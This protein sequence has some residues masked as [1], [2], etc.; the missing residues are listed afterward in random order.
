MLETN[1]T[2][3]FMELESR[4]N[5]GC[6]SE[7]E[8]DVFRN[9]NTNY[10]DSSPINILQ[11]QAIFAELIQNHDKELDKLTGNK[12]LPSYYVELD[13]FISHWWL[14]HSRQYRCLWLRNLANRNGITFQDVEADCKRHPRF[15]TETLM[16]KEFKKTR[17][18]ELDQ[19]IKENDEN[20]DLAKSAH[21]M[22]EEGYKGVYSIVGFH[23]LEKK[24]RV[25]G[26]PKVK[27]QIIDDFLLMH[28]EIKSPISDEQALN[29]HV[30]SLRVLRE[31]FQEGAIKEIWYMYGALASSINH[32]NN[33]KVIEPDDDLEVNIFLSALDRAADLMTREQ[34][35]TLLM[36]LYDEYSNDQEW[37]KK[38]KKY[39]KTRVDQNVSENVRFAEDRTNPITIDPIELPLLISKGLYN[40]QEYKKNPYRCYDAYIQYHYFSGSTTIDDDIHFTEKEFQLLTE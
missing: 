38:W 37:S 18:E 31:M 20:S 8:L 11:D 32:F 3:S 13:N 40:I 5:K 19:I 26:P 35:Y 15:K 2:L 6:I 12:D 33:K 14:Y 34:T 1:R 4:Y 24:L 29:N 25:I 9:S 39:A 27:K 17:D 23:A 28:K 7:L 30:P 10:S 21:R 16:K 36:Y 22:K